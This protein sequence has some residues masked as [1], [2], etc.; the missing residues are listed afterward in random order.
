[1]VERRS[2]VIWLGRTDVVRD[3]GLEHRVAINAVLVLLI[4]ARDGRGGLSR[5]CIRR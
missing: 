3:A 4:R 5:L 1:M 2:G